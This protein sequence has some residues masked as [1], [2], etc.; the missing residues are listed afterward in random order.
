MGAAGWAFEELAACAHPHAVSVTNCY[1]S[2][3]HAQTIAIDAAITGSIA[4]AASTVRRTGQASPLTQV[5]PF[6]TSK[7]PR[8]CALLAI[9]VI[10][11]VALPIGIIGTIVADASQFQGVEAVGWRAGDVAAAVAV[12]GEPSQTGL[13]EERVAYSAHQAVSNSFIALIAH[14]LPSH[15]NVSRITSSTV[16]STLAGPAILNSLSTKRA[17]ASTIDIVP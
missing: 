9:G 10:A 11:R 14:T 4:S 13:A 12:G 7:T 16:S 17:E 8:N 5:K 2:V 1:A 15:K 6:I 3:V